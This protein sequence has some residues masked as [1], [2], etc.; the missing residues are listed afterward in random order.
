MS[1]LAQSFIGQFEKLALSFPMPA[2]TYKDGRPKTQKT[3]IFKISPNGA[4]P[5]AQNS[6]NPGDV[7]MP[8]MNVTPTSQEVMNP[9]SSASA[10]VMATAQA[11]G[12]TGSLADYAGNN[13]PLRST[14][15]PQ[16]LALKGKQKVV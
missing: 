9:G 5:S 15:V 6:S 12:R 14:P 3:Q 1:K 4:N 16:A 7:N 11:A 8:E 13:D 2:G 10:K